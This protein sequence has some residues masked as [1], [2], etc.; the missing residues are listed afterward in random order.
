VAGDVVNLEEFLA[1]L[2]RLGA[3]AEDLPTYRKGATAIIVLSQGHRLTSEHVA[4]AL[5][6]GKASALGE[7]ELTNLLKI[8]NYLLR[9]QNQSGQ[10]TASETPADARAAPRA[11]DAPAAGRVARATGA[12]PR[13]EERVRNPATS[14]DQETRSSDSGLYGPN[15]IS[16]LV[17]LP[18]AP[19]P[20]PKPSEGPP[21]GVLR[22]REVVFNRPSQTVEV[23]TDAAKDDPGGEDDDL[24]LAPPRRRRPLVVLGAVVAVAAAVM[25]GRAILRKPSGP[26]VTKAP[27][28]R[29]TTTLP[30]LGLQV[31]L[32]D[33]WRHAAAADR[34]I[35]IGPGGRA[36]PTSLVYRAGPASAPGSELLVAVL[37]L[38]GSLA[39]QPGDE[40]LLS[41]TGRGHAGG[42]ALLR[43]RHLQ[44]HA[45]GCR[46]AAVGGKRAG[47]CS[48]TA[49]QANTSASLR[50]Y[51]VVGRAHAFLA[52][53]VDRSGEGSGVA[54]ADGIVASLSDP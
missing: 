41:V 10:R 54:E 20:A 40:A 30:S 47:L 36:V 11:A 32:P 26:V 3:P 38:S 31:R 4:N 16:G 7:V 43:A 25:G 29:A 24:E 27:A 12:V 23:V 8:G 18:L 46:I 49:T 14:P 42:L 28:T 15:A 52:L 2:V 22:Q 17:R 34:E 44:V 1:W 9:F 6:A 48:G 5:A 33:G 13:V 21:S 45:E 37:P 51:L 53:L 35:A 19:A 50:T 39:G